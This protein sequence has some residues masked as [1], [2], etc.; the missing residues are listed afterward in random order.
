MSTDECERPTLDWLTGKV[1]PAAPPKPQIRYATQGQLA[2]Q[3]AGLAKATQAGL[4]GERT[5]MLAKLEQ[6]DLRIAMLERRLAELEGR[7][8]EQPLA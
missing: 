2:E 5:S 4:R 8:R 1:Q 3:I 7:A 6:R